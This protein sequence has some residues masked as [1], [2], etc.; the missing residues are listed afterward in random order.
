MKDKT[1]CSPV[2]LESL[3]EGASVR[4]ENDFETWEKVKGFWVVPY[5]NIPFTSKSLVHYHNG[6]RY[7]IIKE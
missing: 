6:A 2:K 1:Y 5:H 4:F 3:S 7:K